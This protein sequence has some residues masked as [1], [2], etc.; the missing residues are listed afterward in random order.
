MTAVME[1]TYARECYSG[2]LVAELM[3]LLKAHYLEIS[4]NQDI[5]LD[6]EWSVYEGCEKNGTLRVYTVRAEGRLIGYE[7]LFV[8]ANP[9]YRGSLQ[10]VQDILFVSK[11]YRHGSLGYRLIKFADD[12]LKK[13]GVQIVYHH[14]KAAHN[15]GPMLE[16]LDYKLVDLIYARRLDRE[17]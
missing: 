4:A 13:E 16:R 8:R 5:P 2:M 12:E 11:E 1:L 6:P 14:V 10:A 17:G 7:V 3:P 9:H 15:F